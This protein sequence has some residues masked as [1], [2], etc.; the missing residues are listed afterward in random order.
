M[1]EMLPPRLQ[2]QM[3]HCSEPAA[4]TPRARL[5]KQHPTTPGTT[6]DHWTGATPFTL[7]MLCPFCTEARPSFE[8]LT[9]RAVAKQ[10][11]RGKGRTRN[12]M[13]LLPPLFDVVR[14]S[15][16]RSYK[17]NV[18]LPVPPEQKLLLRIARLMLRLR[19]PLPLLSVA[20]RDSL[21]C[22]SG[23]RWSAS[24]Q[25]LHSCRRSRPATLA[26]RHRARGCRQARPSHRPSFT[27]KQ[28]VLDRFSH[29][30]LCHP[31]AATTQRIWL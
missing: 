29:K 12:R 6:W 3:G 22:F 16:C 17:L 10:L 28:P 15:S 20:S 27:K 4:S 24:D 1:Q 7:A 25:S 19:L 26:A 31:A 2:R 21:H 18:L 8:R 23:S 30:A 11:A 5:L 13:Q 9:A 14:R